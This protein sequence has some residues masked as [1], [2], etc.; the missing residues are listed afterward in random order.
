MVVGVGT[1]SVSGGL[2]PADATSTPLPPL[3]TTG[4]TP[5][6][7]T[8]ADQGRTIVMQVGE[9]FLLNLGDGAAW[10]V[11][12]ADPSVL[13]P[14]TDVAIPEG[15]QGLFEALAAGTTSLVATNDPPCRKLRPACT[16]PTRSFEVTVVVK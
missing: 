7:V 5:P 1:A 3:Q 4:S 9:R 8:L 14:V 2:V 13:G 6:E 16:L 10:V 12:I 11:E 15:A